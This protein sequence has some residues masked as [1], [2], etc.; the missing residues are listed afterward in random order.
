MFYIMRQ[1]GS[2]KGSRKVKVDTIYNTVY[3]REVGLNIFRDG[4]KVLSKE[5]LG[6][7]EI[8]F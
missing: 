7:V 1:I 3:N 8:I 6:A 4:E 2:N 5:K